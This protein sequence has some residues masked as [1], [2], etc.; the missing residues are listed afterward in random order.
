MIREYLHINVSIT[1]MSS[2]PLKTHLR[3][4]PSPSKSNL[5]RKQFSESQHE[6]ID[7]WQEQIYGCSPQQAP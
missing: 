2:C 5:I 4:A 1:H 7:E 3:A 6:T